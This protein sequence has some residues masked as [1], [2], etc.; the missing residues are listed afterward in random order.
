MDRRVKVSLKAK[1]QAPGINSCR[2][3]WLKRPWKLIPEID[4]DFKVVGLCKVRIW[5]VETG[6]IADFTFPLC[7]SEFFEVDHEE[8]SV[9]ILRSGETD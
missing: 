9:A 7:E 4:S 8:F 6:R 2:R 1:R 3:C 5:E